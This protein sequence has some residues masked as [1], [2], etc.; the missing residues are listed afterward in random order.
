[1]WCSFA[2]EFLPDF[3]Y[4]C[5]R[6]G[7]VDKQCEIWL[8]EGEAQQF[9]RNLRFIPERRGLGAKSR[10]EWLGASSGSGGFFG[11]RGSRWFSSGIGSD[12]LYWRKQD[13]EKRYEKEEEVKNLVKTPSEVKDRD[14]TAKKQLF[15]DAGDPQNNA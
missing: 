2:Y 7:H 15:L 13:E 9:S 12:A 11:G 4:T 14:G 1:M 8:E 3:C 6:I 10:G 5:G